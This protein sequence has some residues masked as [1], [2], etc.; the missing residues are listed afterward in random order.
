MAPSVTTVRRKLALEESFVVSW[1]GFVGIVV[2]TP[3]LKSA[4]M[5]EF[6]LLGKTAVAPG[7]LVV[8]KLVTESLV[9]PGKG[10]VGVVVT[11]PPLKPA[12]ME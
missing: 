8:P 1:R 3:S 12:L 4:S 11:T 10:F 6:A 7:V 9:L 2:T 5:E